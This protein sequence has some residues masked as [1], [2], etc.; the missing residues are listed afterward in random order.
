MQIQATDYTIALILEP[1]EADA[2]LDVINR[3]QLTAAKQEIVDEIHY[4]LGDFVSGPN[5]D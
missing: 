1:L 3:I 2:L 5:N 4:R